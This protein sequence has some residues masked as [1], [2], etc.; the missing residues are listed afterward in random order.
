MIQDHSSAHRGRKPVISIRGLYKAFGDLEVLRGIDL[1]VFPA[2]NVVVLGKSG[3][4]KSVLIK[5][6]VGL[7]KPDDGQVE[8]LGKQVTELRPRQLDAL[9]VRVG[10]SF[11]HS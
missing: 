10:F 5:I 11:Q 4:G 2:E 6:I 9:R 1:D 7:L 8:V 3:T